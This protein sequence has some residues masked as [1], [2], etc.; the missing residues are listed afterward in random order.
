MKHEAW[1]MKHEAWRIK[2]EARSTK[3]EA[4]STKHEARSTKHE[5]RNTKHEAQSIQWLHIWVNY[6]NKSAYRRIG[7]PAYQRISVSVYQSLAIPDWLTDCLL[8]YSM[9]KWC[10]CPEMFNDTL[11]GLHNALV[12]RR[13]LEIWFLDTA[14]FGK[15]TKIIP[16][17]L[18]KIE[19]WNVHQLLP[20]VYSVR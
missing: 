2:H 10:K 6:T 9:T 12:F 7:V 16:E 15:F 17:Q 4:R 1:S 13:F 20:Y 19:N 18:Q 8:Y 14:V 5:T 3:H 11:R